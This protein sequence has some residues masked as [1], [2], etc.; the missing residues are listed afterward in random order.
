MEQRTIKPNKLINNIPHYTM[1]DAAEVLGMSVK[2]LKRKMELRLIEY[3]ALG[4]EKLFPAASVDEYYR[5]HVV[6]TKTFLKGVER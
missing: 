6:R 1:A 5:R 2:T 3:V 4:R